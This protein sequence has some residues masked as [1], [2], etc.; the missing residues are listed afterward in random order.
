[1]P[2]CVAIERAFEDCL[3]PVQLR[4]AVMGETEGAMKLDRP[5]SGMRI[6]AMR[7][8]RGHADRHLAAALV[9]ET[10][11]RAV[12]MRPRFFIF[13]IIFDRRVFQRLEAADNLVELLARR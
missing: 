3:A 1:M 7:L 2:G 5:V 6:G 12:E 8:R 9:T 13:D 11:R 10:M 4:I